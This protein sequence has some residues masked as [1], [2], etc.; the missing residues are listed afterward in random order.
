MCNCLHVGISLGPIFKQ[1]YY[2]NDNYEN[3]F[4]QYIDIL[5]GT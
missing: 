2:G 1:F 4:P 3:I 5:L